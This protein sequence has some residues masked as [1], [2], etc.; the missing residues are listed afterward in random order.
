MQKKISKWTAY[1]SVKGFLAGS[2]S[3]AVTALAPGSCGFT[4]DLSVSFSDAVLGPKI[5]E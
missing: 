3:F 2:P 1:C 4:V 5:I